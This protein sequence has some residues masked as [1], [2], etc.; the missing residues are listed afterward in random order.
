MLLTALYA[1]PGALTP[2]AF[3]P[4][5]FARLLETDGVGT[6]FLV[7]SVAAEL[8][9]SAALTGRDLSR[10]HLVGC[11]AAPL[12]PAVA[13]RLATTFANAA[14]V[15]YYTSTEAA[16]AEASMVFDPARPDAVGRAAD[17]ALMIADPTGA[18]V[19]AGVTGDVWLRCPFPREYYR[20]PHA[21]SAVFRDGWVRMGDVGWLDEQGY[22]HLTDRQEDVVKSGAFKL[23]TLEVEA[24][25]HEHPHVAQAAVVGVPHPVLGSVLAAFVVPRP[26][27]PSGEPGLATLRRFLSTRLADYQVPAAVHLRD[28]LPRNQGGKVLKRVLAADAAPPA[29]TEKDAA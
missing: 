21:T 7:P 10:I 26:G 18:P 9:D 6:V 28:E 29:P 23:S 8:L 3:T 24:A 22:L 14:V 17:G 13:V 15:N 2:A 11:T 16:P 5:R 25:L 19:P 20:D 27:A 12:P 1:R 4:A